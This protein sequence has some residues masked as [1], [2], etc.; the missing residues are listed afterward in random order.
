MKRQHLDN[1]V[2]FSILVY[3]KELIEDGSFDGSH[4]KG[5]V[6]LNTRRHGHT[7]FR[8]PDDWKDELEY[9]IQKYG[10]RIF[11]ASQFHGHHKAEEAVVKPR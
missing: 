4:F 11:D 5:A 8:V 1:R 7:K 9:L 10:W 6:E 3:I 2:V